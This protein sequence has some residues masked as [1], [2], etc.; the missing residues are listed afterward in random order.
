[1]LLLLVHLEHEH[2]VCLGLQGMA[3]SF[4][5]TVSRAPG[6]PVHGRRCAMIHDGTGVFKDIPQKFEVVRYNSLLADVPTLPSCLR[7]NCTSESGEIMGLVHH[8]R[9]IHG[10]QFHPESIAS[11]HG[12]QLMTNFVNIVRAYQ[13]ITQNIKTLIKMDIHEEKHSD[14]MPK[15]RPA[16]HVPAPVAVASATVLTTS[17]SVPLSSPSIAT[18]PTPSKRRMIVKL[19]S[20]QW[21]EPEQV[22]T[23]L[24]SQTKPAFWLDSSRVS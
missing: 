22:F 15:P 14:F 2:R 1:M 19:P 16:L 17:S 7:V 4:G 13:Q 18:N 12:E 8:D 20:S 6:G 5:G 24:Y 3:T 9:P 23:E 11:D 21:I 10:V